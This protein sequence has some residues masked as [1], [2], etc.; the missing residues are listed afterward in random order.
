M[1][2]RETGSKGKDFDLMISEKQKVL[3]ERMQKNQ[4]LLQKSKE[5]RE[6]SLNQPET[7]NTI[8]LGANNSIGDTFKEKTEMQLSQRLGN[9]L[10]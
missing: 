2:S 6:G 10:R 5:L 9:I 4:R 7:I 3:T 8:N 1:T